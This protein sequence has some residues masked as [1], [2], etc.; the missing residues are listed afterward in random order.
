M[1]DEFGNRARPAFRMRG[2]WVGL[3]AQRFRLECGCFSRK[4]FDGTDYCLPAFAR[5]IKGD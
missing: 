4:C 3:D 1:S 5:S 2:L